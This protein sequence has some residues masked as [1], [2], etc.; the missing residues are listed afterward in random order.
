VA[1]DRD[2]W[3][4]LLAREAAQCGALAAVGTTDVMNHALAMA[5][6]DVPIWMDYF[7]DPMAE[8]QM[9]A[10][11]LGSDG[12]LADQWAL[13]A[14]A[15]AR[16]DRLSGC[17]TAQCGAIEG[18]L[19]AMGRLGR[20]T[21]RERLVHRI[22]P[23]IEP[24][25]R[26]AAAAPVLRGVRVPGDAFLVIQTGGFNTWLDVQTLFEGLER[27][28]AA[29]PR[30]HFAATG[31]AIP[32]HG[33]GGFEWF[34]RAAQS[35]RFRSRYHL[36]GW[37]PLAQVPQ[38]IAE[39]DATL[40]VDL[41]CAEGRLGTRNR[42]MDWL[43]GRAAVISTPGC[44]LAI[45]LGDRGYIDLIP[46]GAPGAVAEAL[47]RVVAQ[48]G[49]AR[50][51]AAAGEQYLREAHRPATCLKPL[52]DWAREPKPASDLLNEAGQ[53]KDPRSL[54]SRALGAVALADQARRLAARA[55]WLQ[56]R[57][58]R[59]E[60]SRLVRWALFVRGRGDLEDGPPDRQ[61]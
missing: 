46:H 33:G 49:E 48:P 16:A 1:G 52:L 31:G 61:P 53:G 19:G 3:G 32:G 2:G 58:A 59:I 6:L 47:A 41:E 57:L 38:V 25:Q 43:L 44:E 8:R 24:I 28:M 40:N 36:L 17:S 54:R 42:L 13:V 14:P 7:G 20:H 21:A 50:R 29:E 15:L 4:P 39:A 12:G 45:E 55:E 35:S 30:L 23:W 26:P 9:L 22:P 5:G 10:L 11:R 18:Q 60:G 27:A 51:R 56:R 34:E 37:L